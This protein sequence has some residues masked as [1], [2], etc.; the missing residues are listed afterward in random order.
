MCCIQGKRILY[1]IGN[2]FDLA[3]QDS[4]KSNFL[5]SYNDFKNYIQYKYNGGG[6]NIL[7]VGELYNFIDKIPGVGENWCDFENSLS[8]INYDYVYQLLSSRARPNLKTDKIDEF[9]DLIQIDLEHSFEAW[10]RN[11]DVNG[12]PIYNID[13]S[14]YFLTF[15][16]TKTLQKLYGID[17]KRICHIHGGLDEHNLTGLRFIFGHGS[18]S[19]RQM[20]PD[21]LLDSDKTEFVLALERF[22]KDY[23][24][25]TS[26]NGYRQMI[27]YCSK[28]E[29]III[30]GHGLGDV[31]LTYFQ[32]I[33]QHTQGIPWYYY[34][35][36]VKENSSKYIER[37]EKIAHKIQ[38]LDE[39]ELKFKN[40]I[41]CT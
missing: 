35:Y 13:K 36:N 30:I 15:N 12:T 39:K 16:Y 9:L 32:Q 11:I 19:I 31:D 41:N 23:H 20:H 28:V 4:G 5:T 25:I 10:V 3:H 33:A 24:N 18:D 29:K 40:Q 6:L 34:G 22:K 7:N 27:D 21:Y 1:I 8:M 14:G 26:T 17:S 2:G 38:L 37:I